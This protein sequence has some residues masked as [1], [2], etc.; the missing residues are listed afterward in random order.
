MPLTD[1]A[2]SLTHGRT[3]LSFTSTDAGHGYGLNVCDE[4]GV[5]RS[6]STADNR[7][8]GGASLDLRPSQV[9]LADEQTISFSGDSQQPY[10]G[11]VS[12]D[13]ATGWFW[14]DLTVDLPNGLTL[15]MADGPEPQIMLD[16]GNLPPYE[17]GDHVWFM[18]TV[19]NPTKW[20][21]DAHGNDMP[22]TYLYDSYLKAELLMFFD[23]T[24]MSW[25][26]LKNTGRFLN[27]RCGYRR[28]YQ[29]EPAA[30]LGLYLENTSG[31]EL[32]PGPLRIRYAIAAAPRLHGPTDHEAVQS[33]VE[34]CL[35]LLPTISD[36][37]SR[38]TSW[39][40]FSQNC[41]RDLLTDHAWHGEPDNEYLLNY[42]D[43][44][45]PAWKEALIAR[46]V[47]FDMDKPC[48]ES[49]V[50]GAHPL[51]V[52]ARLE[53]K[54]DY[55]A[56][57]RRM[58][59]FI[60]RQVAAGRSPLALGED[61]PRGTWQHFYVV[62]QLFQ[63][64]RASG[65]ETL[66]QQI[67]R[68]ADAVMIPFAQRM[69]YM[70]PLSFG[71]RNLDRRGSGDAH[72][73]SGIFA[74]LMLDLHAWTGEQRYLDE[75]RNA[76]HVLYRLPINT[77]HQEVFMLGMATHA[78]SRLAKM[79]DE[80]E[81]AV[82]ARY[83][84]A[85]TLRMMHWFND[86]TGGNEHAV[87]TLGMFQACATINYPAIFENIETLARLAAAMPTLPPSEAL[88]RVFDHARKTNFHF[89]PE[90]FDSADGFPL[91]F[92]PLENIWI[93]E[94]PKPSSVGAEIYGA[95]WVFRAYLLW[96]AFGRCV[97]REIMV[98]NCSAFDEIRQLETGRWEIE[99]YVFNS[100]DQT[101]EA[102]LVFPIAVERQATLVDGE[103]DH[104]L[105]GGRGSVLLA[106]GQMRKIRLLV[107]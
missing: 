60:D 46:G 40:D 85:Q 93:L 29:P 104:R 68:E 12:I 75:A 58:L 103:H 97:D 66:L 9:S 74:S 90:C 61:L 59:A 81:F 30:S 27:Y 55:S 5:W 65:N 71:N 6:I 73:V 22:A 13:R 41:A 57:H 15:S 88:L 78:A 67:R 102:E 31:T 28:R 4:D 32:P 100:T 52:L 17:R 45:S 49:G 84:Q 107:A 18:T 56:L 79:S 54:A 94:G 38:A 48:L 51:G 69:S 63:V 95:G 82:I 8:L 96:E 62:E 83:F 86:R 105:T 101:R 37:P 16:L 53:T 72:A 34:R 92:V 89:F 33:L 87:Q 35:P 43:A 26:S 77:I 1:S 106:A 80:S 64:A 21:D 14:I 2:I 76:L 98:L 24:A 7:L 99:F 39:Q 91:R 47:P 11:T 50:W 10:A 25:M 70:F 44:D 3:R 19:A 23:F 42:V 36:W 20:N